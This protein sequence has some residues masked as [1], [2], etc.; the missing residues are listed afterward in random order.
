MEYQSRL[1]EQYNQYCQK[2]KSKEIEISGKTL[3]YIVGGQ[4]KETIFIIPGGTGRIEDV[5]QYIL[6]LEEE[7]R[8]IAMT[9]PTNV[10]TIKESENSIMAI[11]NAES[12]QKAHFIGFDMG[13]MIGQQFVH[14][15]PE[16]AMNI[17]LI[18]TLVPNNSIAKLFG[19]AVTVDSL[20]PSFLYS[21]ITKALFSKVLK[22]YLDASQEVKNFWINHYVDSI[23]KE[24]EHNRVRISMDFLK[25][26]YF[27][28]YDLDS[29]S[30][31]V[32]II[33]SEKDKVLGK[34]EILEQV[35]EIYPQAK[36]YTFHE[37]NQIVNEIFKSTT[38]TSLIKD[39]LAKNK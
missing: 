2:H 1:L 6:A 29:W 24:R 31:N 19:K 9:I 33:E 21:K 32:F 16:M 12:I 39:F 8:V 27:T 28:P 23:S 26:Y 36:F 18:H 22:N 11:L 35:R 37:G 3:D 7:Y 17:V 38:I 10:T 25:N 34:K 4:G 30:G 13:S 5:F 20:I 15:Y 14:H